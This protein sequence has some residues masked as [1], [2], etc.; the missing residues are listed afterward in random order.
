MTAFRGSTP[1]QGIW[2]GDTEVEAVYHGDI[3]VWQSRLPPTITTTVLDPMVEGVAFSQQLQATGTAP[4]TWAVTAGTIVPGLTLTTGGL[5][6]GT[7]TAAGPYDFTVQASNTAGSDTQQYTGSVD[8]GAAVPDPPTAVVAALNGYEIDLTWNAP[9]D[10]GNPPAPLTYDIW[11]DNDGGGYVEVATGVAVTNWTDTTPGVETDATYQVYA[12]NP[13]G[14]STPATSNTVTVP[15]APALPDAP[16]L[17]TAT[18]QANFDIQVEIFPPLDPGYPAAPITYRIQRDTGSGFSDIAT[19]VS[20]TSFTDTDKIASATITYRVFATNPTGEGPSTD[21]NTVDNTAVPADP[22]NAV[23]ALDA[24]DSD[25]NLTWDAPVD[26]GN[27]PDV[28]YTIQ[29]SVDAGGYVEVATGVAVT[30]WTDTTT[31]PST[32][33]IYRVFAVNSTGTS[34]FAQTNSVDVPAV[35]PGDEPVFGGGIIIEDGTH[36]RHLFLASG[37]LVVASPGDAEYLVAAGGGGGNTRGNF[38][39]SGG[40]GAGGVLTGSRNFSANETVIVGAGGAYNANGSDSS[41]GATTAT[42]GGEAAGG[43]GGSGGGG[44]AISGTP[45]P[46]GTGIPGQGHDGGTTDLGDPA[47][48]PGG[49]GGGAA[50]V[51]VNGSATGPAG[52]NGGPGIEWPA[53]S[54]DYY[55]G[56]GGGG[57]QT[58]RQCFSGWIRTVCRKTQRSSIHKGNRA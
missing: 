27:P 47:F 17:V 12:V 20:G 30:N 58:L 51:G 42:G 44:D 34:G 16:G 2:Q 36:R 18:P 6:S 24:N 55:G 11:R 13:T 4:I 39:G 56:G 1:L 26:P 48:G 5:L 40:A 28:T 52:G 32:T 38:T 29:R 45:Q 14:S 31:T 33:V 50:A 57:I 3:L 22:T 21:S 15:P 25:V 54:G 46:P 53:G 8:A 9:G 43:S 10:P 49:G 23:A 41:L 35:G 19:G 37:T 7:P